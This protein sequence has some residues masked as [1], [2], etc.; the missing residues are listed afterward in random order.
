MNKWLFEAIATP[1]FV[2]STR[3]EIIEC[4]SP[5]SELL[6]SIELTGDHQNFFEAF[7][8]HQFDQDALYLHSQL[9]QGTVQYNSTIIDQKRQVRYIQWSLKPM[10]DQDTDS[11]Q[12]VATGIEHT[13][14]RSLQ[15]DDLAWQ[16]PFDNVGNLVDGAIYIFDVLEGRNV[17]VSREITQLLGY[18]PERIQEWGKDL[19][20]SLLHP[21]DVPRYEKN[22]ERIANATD[23]QVIEF[24]YR[25][26]HA[27]GHW[28]WISSSE[29]VVRRTLD[30]TP[31][32]MLGVAKDITEFK[33]TRLH[34]EHAKQRLSLHMENS[35]LA[36][37]EWDKDFRVQMW[38]G[39]AEKLFVWS[40][41]EVIGLYPTE[42]QFV[43]EEDQDSVNAI[44]AELLS[45]RR[46]YNVSP[47]RNYTKDGRILHCEW[48]NTVLFD[49]EG[50]LVSI[51]SL[52]LDVT[53][54][55][56]T[57]KALEESEGIYRTL[58]QNLPNTSVMV[59]DK[60]LRYRLVEDKIMRAA[61]YKKSDV[62]GKTLY[63]VLPPDSIEMVLDDYMS[64]LGGKTVE[65]EM[66]TGG[67]A[68]YNSFMPV[69]GYENEVVGG[70]VVSQDITV[71]KETERRSYELALEQEKISILK[72]FIN[73]LSH[74]FR[75]PLTSLI[76]TVYLVKRKSEILYDQL[77]LMKPALTDWNAPLSEQIFALMT[78]I[79]RRGANLE[80]EA[81]RFQLIVDSILETLYIEDEADEHTAVE[82][83]VQTLKSVT[84][85]FEPQAMNKQLSMKYDLRQ[86]RIMVKMSAEKLYNVVMHLL[87]N[88]I[89]YTPQGGQIRVTAR[90]DGQYAVL[91]VIDTGIGLDEN[92]QKQIFEWFFRADKA[93][94]TSTGGAGMG[95]AKVKRILQIAGGDIRV[96]S[97]LGEGTTFTVRLP[98]AE[99]AI[100]ASTSG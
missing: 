74:D 44:M 55:L 90:V 43:Y 8:H 47:N 67:R 11:S 39:A 84:Q 61:G 51:L 52:V 7:P 66:V 24:E 80:D 73:E 65:R 64:A 2:L 25:M 48:Y 50:Q 15:V 31:Q 3:G 42:W 70:M 92:D 86:D 93:R 96:E 99:S 95:L 21:D 98:L 30:G 18:T 100:P 85:Q 12:I 63:E 76:T 23:E 87:R 56:E 17:Y 59:F 4:N 94:R 41:E 22:I 33:E 16:V 72:K 28:V 81:M 62:E 1:V 10:L 54:R 9:Q 13:Q 27:D 77:E 38:S 88:A 45:K 69:H 49:D 89:K 91:K 20:Q 60:D 58:V 68:Y 35:P 71:F 46:A 37:I 26:R 32:H 79:A 53:E 34:L 97:Q 6:D 57:R 29:K 82:D 40:D 36:I 83:L 19:V 14:Y 78:D 5:A 75:T